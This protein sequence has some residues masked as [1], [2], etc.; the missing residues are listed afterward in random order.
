MNINYIGE[1]ILAGAL[2]RSFIWASILALI[3][4]LVLYLLSHRK[5]ERKALYERMAGNLFLLHFISL[6]SSFCTL[7]YL[8]F[9][10]Y[11][12]YSYVWQYSAID[13]P[14]K[15]LVSCLWAGQEGSF[16]IWGVL[17]GMLGL[18]LIRKSGEWKSWVMPIFSV[19]Q[20]FLIS[21]VLGFDIG[22]IKIG[23]SPFTLL[24]ELPQNTGLDLFKEPNYVGM[25]ID[26][27][28]L[29]PLLENIWM[30]I[31]PP[32]L[33]LGYAVSLVPFSYAVASLWRGQYH[34]WIKPALP[35]TLASILTLGIGILL[36]G[37]W[38]Y[39][40]LTFGGFWAWDP[41]ENASLVPWLFLIA[42][43]HLMLIANKRFHSYATAYLFSFLGWIFVVYATYLTRSGVLGETSV[44][45]FGDSGKAVQMLLFIAI[46]LFVPLALLL[47][48]KKH[49]PVKEG[50]EILSR[51]F[52]M[53]IGSVVVVLSAFQVTLTTSI[54]VIN[55]V[56]GTGIAPPVDNVNYY[57]TWQLPFGL[58]VVLL[59]GISQYLFYGR[60]E[61][62]TFLK[63]MIFT[64]SITALLTVI[65]ALGDGIGRINHILLL[66][67]VLFAT[68]VSIDFIV[69]YMRK[70][71][72][73]GSSISHAGF[74]LFMLGVLLA[75]SN[76]QIISRNTSGVN[77]GKEKDNA[78]NLVLM[79]GASQAMGNYLVTYSSNESKGRETFYKVDFVLKED[80][81]N[82]KV[83]FSVY[84]SVNHNM[85][86]GNVYNPDTKHFLNKDIYTFISFSEQTEGEADS[87]GYK[88]SGVEEMNVHDTI[89]YARSYII[90][91]SIH[92]EMNGDDA[93]NA[94]LT[95]HFRILSMKE[96]ILAA[97]MKYQVKNGELVREDAFVKPLDLKFRFEG[98]SPNSRAI[99]VGVYEKNQDFIVI[100]AVIFPYM[101]VLWLGAIIMFSGLVFSIIRRT[102]K[103]PVDGA[104]PKV[105]DSQK[106][107][108]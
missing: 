37:R 49:F 39:E 22:G 11:F 7:Y 79:K 52:W 98:I 46:F 57:N 48:R 8:I 23:G 27:N 42:S 24:R 71:T 16:M 9:N 75:F 34:S 13:L 83:A 25:I 105:S 54:P 84:P 41:V 74:A 108:V 64:A 6:L 47:F 88:R 85:K 94:L 96:G 45:A 103:K 4:S 76:S 89:L 60:N 53:L 3:F 10:H 93:N 67:F 81:A 20:L 2:G 1:H 104:D 59:I 102:W 33:F 95:A 80:G 82:G 56:F 66:F 91:D 36:G 107:S 100:K 19:G 55:K 72:N 69:K 77:L 29:N 97:T 65:I 43:L 106:H 14:L 58:L 51:E 17:Q 5:S 90:L 68:V 50:D 92:A 12:E 61:L 38:A 86:M 18:I 21:M 28:G 78:E 31:H 63:K 87:S 15:F 26:G 35:W 30:I 40:S 101:N 32:S 99:M 62:R 44:H 70:T 73:L